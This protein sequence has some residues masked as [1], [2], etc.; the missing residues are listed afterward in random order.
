MIKNKRAKTQR[1][2]TLIE[3]LVVIS[4]IAVLMGILL[5]SLNRAREAA[6]RTMCLSNQRTVAVAMSSY[7]ADNNGKLF[8]RY[9]KTDATVLWKNAVPYSWP[10]V[11]CVDLMK[12]YIGLI[13]AANCPTSKYESYFI[14]DSSH[15]H[16]GDWIVNLL[17]LPGLYEHGRGIPYDTIPSVASVNISVS[18]SNRLLVADRNNLHTNEYWGWSN[19]S[20]GETVARDVQTFIQ[21]VKGGNRVYTDGHGEWVTIDKMGKNGNPPTNSAQDSRYSHLAG[22]TRPYYW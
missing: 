16:G 7:A 17:W 11:G 2:F 19:H 8:V 21:K 15:S 10:Q 12:P 14:Q 4:I 1:A 9:D 22:G 3:L 5:P 18:S 20:G 13:E 6:K